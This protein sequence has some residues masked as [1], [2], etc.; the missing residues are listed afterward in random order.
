MRRN[1]RCFV[2]FVLEER[3][4]QHRTR[5]SFGDDSWRSDKERRCICRGKGSPILM[6][7]LDLGHNISEREKDPGY[8]C[9]WRWK[10][11]SYGAGCDLLAPRCS[12]GFQGRKEVGMD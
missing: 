1:V 9:S 12:R 11:E 3:T 8:S 10:E 5:G 6:S 4:E 7:W 2:G